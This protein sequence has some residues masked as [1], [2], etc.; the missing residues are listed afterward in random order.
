MKLTERLFN[1][2]S[3]AATP[4]M[5][6][7]QE[8]VDFRNGAQWTEDEKKKL[9]RRKQKA[10]VD[11]V[12]KP[13][14]EQAKAL[15]T[16][17]RPRFSS[18]AQE[19][20]DVRTGKMFSELMS[21]IWNVSDGD[22]QH[23]LV[24]D[25][26][27]VKG[28][29]AW[30]IDY[31]AHADFGKGEVFLRSLDP[32]ELYIDPNAKDFF[33]RD[34]AHM[35]IVRRVTAE[36]IQQTLPE[37]A[38]EILALGRPDSTDYRPLSQ[39]SGDEGQTDRVEE[40]EHQKYRA[41]DRYS[42]VKVTYTN[43]V[44]KPD[45]FEK[46]LVLA[47]AKKYFAAPAMIMRSAK[48][49]RY[50]TEPDEVAEA[51]RVYQET[52]G[53]F[54]YIQDPT[55]GQPV[56][57]PGPA[58]ENAIPDSETQ[59]IPTT[60]AALLKAGIFDVRTYYENRIQR[61]FDIGGV[62][63]FD[64]VLP[65]SSYPIVPVMN[66]WDRNPYPMSDVRFV[67]PIQ[68]YINK[69]ESLIMLHAAN[70]SNIKVIAPEGTNIENLERALQKPGL[71]VGKYN[72]ELG[73]P[74]IGAPIPLPNELYQNVAMAKASIERILG[75]Y[76]FMQGNMEKAPE[77]Y[78][79]TIAMDENAQRRI[80]SKLADVEAALTQLGRVV[81]E[82][83]QA[84]YTEH[85][86]IRI[87]EPNHE[88]RQVE[89]NVPIYDTLGEDVIERINDVTVGRYDIVLVSGSM[90]PANRWA[91]FDYYVQL[92]QLGLI[93]QVEVLKQTEV[94]DMEGVLNRHNEILQ[95]RQQVEQLQEQL[96]QVSGDLQTAQRESV[97]DRKR[98]EVEKFKGKL[99]DMEAQG[100]AAATVFTQRLTDTL[101]TYR[102]SMK[103]QPATTEM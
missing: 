83:I 48:G 1:A 86:V 26:Y 9:K 94:V 47:E 29:G 52:G 27:Y 20:S 93:D 79:G 21:Y 23:K 60:N 70:A 67:R 103:P 81:V 2:Y 58:G 12:I 97:Q 69:L 35:M 44:R 22:I 92:Y 98:V 95:L 85:K 99:K 39:Q 73:Q 80:R 13:A 51:T 101:G 50:L 90:L 66:H 36:Q 62:L 68:Q 88:Q 75:I 72:P 82:M 55:T 43:I 87:L 78:K 10:I 15:L 19:D 53:V 54:H 18:A 28:M 24:I 84:Y 74:V 38:H 46:V 64:G 37:K 3:A 8:D 71:A 77:T 31:D 32:R 102:E 4:W 61:V 30:F 100:K 96:K 49:D 42:R 89:I 45:N 7:L 34:A 57:Q 6:Q 14:V 65:I 63:I 16:A 41:I 17:N 76:E 59:I 33:A 11:N 91:R 25:D 40:A 5:Q 56:M